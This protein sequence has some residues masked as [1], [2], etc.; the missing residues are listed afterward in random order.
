MFI[1]KGEELPAHPAAQ[2]G[3]ASKEG[4]NARRRRGYIFRCSSQ[5]RTKSG[6]SP[7]LSDRKALS[8]SRGLTP[9]FVRLDAVQ[10]KKYPRLHLTSAPSFDAHPHC[11]A[12]WPGNS[13]RRVLKDK[14]HREAIQMG[15]E[16]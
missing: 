16:G 1:C 11:T 3:W 8:A 5:A 9:L 13:S 6:V 2:R 12:G 14:T 7:R 4:A 10:L 15:G